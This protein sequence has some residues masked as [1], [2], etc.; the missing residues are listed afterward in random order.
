MSLPSV[1]NAIAD[2]DLAALIDRAGR[3]GIAAWRV[4]AAL[5]LGVRAA[6]LPPKPSK[7]NSG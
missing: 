7:D 1:P 3:L 2:E 4:T 5:G 6:E